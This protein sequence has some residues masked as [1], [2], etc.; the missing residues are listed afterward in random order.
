MA[1]DINIE[2]PVS[3]GTGA[4]GPSAGAVD[5]NGKPIQLKSDPSNL[6]SGP[7]PKAWDGKIDLTGAIPI[8]QVGTATAPAM[9][10]NKSASGKID[11]TGA[12][13][14]SQLPRTQQAPAPEPTGIVAGVS[15]AVHNLLSLPGAVKDAYSKPPQDDEERK[16]V[17]AD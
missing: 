6:P 15:R 3:S 14:I 8:E 10:K 1:G 11:L 5:S 13:P 16:L 12:T 4:G 17:E 2:T 7:T 9:S